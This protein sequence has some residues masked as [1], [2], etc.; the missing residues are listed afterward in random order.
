MPDLYSCHVNCKCHDLRILIST[1]I[2]FESL[3][4]IFY[5]GLVSATSKCPC[6]RSCIMCALVKRQVN[7]NLLHAGV[8]VAFGGLRWY[9]RIYVWDTDFFKMLVI[10]CDPPEEDKHIN[11]NIYSKIWLS[12]H[13]VW[14]MRV[15]VNQSIFYSTLSPSRFALMPINKA[16]TFLTPSLVEHLLHKLDVFAPVASKK[17]NMLPNDIYT[18]DSG[19]W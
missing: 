7:F 16:N 17:E 2:I 12:Q 4:H 19:C 10:S 11:V 18:I 13:N 9:I 14:C 15:N 6:C 5:P 1:W 8:C 3:S